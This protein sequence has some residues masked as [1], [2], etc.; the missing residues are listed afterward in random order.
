MGE[1][2]VVLAGS[3]QRLEPPPQ[4]LRPLC[5]CQTGNRGRPEAAEGGGPVLPPKLR[6]EFPHLNGD[7]RGARHRVTLSVHGDV[8]GH[9]QTHVVHPTPIPCTQHTQKHTFP[10]STGPSGPAV[11]P[12]SSG[13]TGCHRDSK[14]TWA[15]SIVLR[16]GSISKW[17]R[18]GHA[19]EPLP[20][21]GASFLRG[22]SAQK[23]SWLLGH[24]GRFARW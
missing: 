22:L 20:D 15:G 12:L 7:G 23:E 11:P 24:R 13:G 3:R 6:L 5:M 19:W 10:I 2:L 17:H 1:T 21:P 16:L 14:G 4:R 9:S 18:G 8:H